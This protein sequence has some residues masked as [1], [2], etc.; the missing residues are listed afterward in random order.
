MRGRVSYCCGDRWR[1]ESEGKQL[2]VFLGLSLPLMSRSGRVCVFCWRASCEY[3]VG[4]LVSI[5]RLSRVREVSEAE[6]AVLWGLSLSSSQRSLV[7]IPSRVSST[8]VTW[9]VRNAICV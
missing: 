8:S 4:A 1:G 6:I 9:L 2:R 3:S 7:L 5:L